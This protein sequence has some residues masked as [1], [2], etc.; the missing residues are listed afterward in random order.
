MPSNAVH[1]FARW[2][3][4]ANLKDEVFNSFEV[5]PVAVCHTFIA[6]FT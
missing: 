2:L 6:S 4:R 3:K 1:F 5:W